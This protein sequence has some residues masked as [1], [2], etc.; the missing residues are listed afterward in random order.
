MA[1][2][3]PVAD[4][5]AAYT[6]CVTKDLDLHVFPPVFSQSRAADD[7]NDYETY[8][9]MLY[10]TTGK[11]FH[12]PLVCFKDASPGALE[13]TLKLEKSKSGILT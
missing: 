4:V 1:G 6:T 12:D 3:V 7:W 2:V 11:P 13:R 5:D 9:P 10:C 8:W